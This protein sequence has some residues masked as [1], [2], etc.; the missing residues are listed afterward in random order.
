MIK[1]R[2]I[3][4]G[5][6]KSLEIRTGKDD[7]KEEPEGL[8]KPEKEAESQRKKK[9]IESFVRAIDFLFLLETGFTFGVSST[10][11]NRSGNRLSLCTNHFR[12][13]IFIIRLV[14]MYI[15][16][17]VFSDVYFIFVTKIFIYVYKYLKNIY[18]TLLK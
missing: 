18:C 10:L 8:K 7:D 16:C 9:A 5:M 13:S 17:V 3:W 2:A 6:W 11:K 14:Y 15:F 12:V 1:V 4:C